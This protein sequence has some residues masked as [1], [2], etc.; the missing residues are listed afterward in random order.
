[1]ARNSLWF[2]IALRLFRFRSSKTPRN[3]SK[4]SFFTRNYNC[5]NYIFFCA[6]QK[7][8]DEE[9]ILRGGKSGFLEYPGGEILLR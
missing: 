7:I 1:M 5:R 4:P 9:A 8:F 6:S 3:D 2:K